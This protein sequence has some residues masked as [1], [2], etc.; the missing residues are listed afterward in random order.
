M[1]CFCGKPN[2]VLKNRKKVTVPKNIIP[3]P[4][5]TIKIGL[6]RD[7]NQPTASRTSSPGLKICGNR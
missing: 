2:V 7:L 5:Q 4:L 3:L 6:V 1:I